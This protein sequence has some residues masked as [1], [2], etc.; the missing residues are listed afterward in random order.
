MTNCFSMVKPK[1]RIK[2][3]KSRRK[4][5]SRSYK[6][7]TSEMLQLAVESVANSTITT[8]EAEKQFGIPRR[9]IVNRLKNRHS[10]PVGKPTRL[11]EEEENKLINVVIASADYGSP[12][13]KLD[14]RI[15]VHNYLKKNGKDYIFNKKMPGE[16]WVNNLL[17][18]HNEKLTVRSTQNIS[19]SRAQ[20][21]EDEL[22][23]YFKNL[24]DTLKDIP[25]ANIL[26]YDETNCSDDPGSLKAIFRRGVKYPE[27]II[28]STKG[29]V[30]LMFSGT[31]DG[32]CLPPYVVYRADNL[33]NE[34]ILNGPTDARYNCTRSGWF[35]AAM[36]EDYFRSVV[37]EWAK[38]LP[39]LKVVIGDNLSSHLSPEIVQLSEDHEIKFVFL[40]PNS[41]HL[42]QPLDIAFFGP[43]KKEWRKILLKYK[44]E[45][46]AQKTVNKK[47]FPTLLK[48]LIE[49][50]ELHQS[51]NLRSGFKAAGIYPLNPRE[52]LKRIPEFEFSD[53]MTYQID[54]SLLDYLKQSRAPNPIKTV[55]NKKIYIEPGKSVSVTDFENRELLEKPGRKGKTKKDSDKPKPKL[56]KMRNDKIKHTTK[57]SKVKNDDTIIYN[58]TPDKFTE[59]VTDDIQNTIYIDNPKIEKREESTVEINILNEKTGIMQTYIKTNAIIEIPKSTILKDNFKLKPKT[60]DDIKKDNIEVY[61]SYI[62]SSSKENVENSSDNKT[63]KT[64]KPVN[65]Q[66]KFNVDK[67]LT[68]K[69]KNAPA[70]RLKILQS[71]SS[72]TT[73]AISMSE[74]SDSDLFDIDLD[75][76]DDPG[77]MLDDSD[78]T[79]SLKLNDIDSMQEMFDEDDEVVKRK[80]YERETE[81]FNEILRIDLEND[82]DTKIKDIKTDRVLNDRNLKKYGHTE[83]IQRIELA[84]KRMINEEQIDTEK[85]NTTIFNIGDNVIVRYYLTKKWQYYVGEITDIINKVENKYK[86]SYYKTI[87]K[88]DHVKFKKPRRPD[89]DVIPHDL[90]VKQVDLLQI[91][92]N[93]EFVLFDDEDSVVY[94]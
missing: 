5:G 71:T 87:S 56:K 15:L 79:H 65:F 20:K 6:N 14:L 84:D 73:E 29:C 59:A 92:E 47:H 27:R 1:P 39:G 86:I 23:N 4:L 13:T 68:K 3:R 60:R 72:T 80:N 21:G 67:V 64:Y 61:D 42:T 55:R 54:E 74:H 85:D 77:V 25:P 34:W 52:V 10:K 82:K 90:I 81:I 78:D 41:T 35:D 8:R 88:K 75:Q 24:R 31:A 32:K 58:E 48:T 91:N 63:T 70:K 93:N 30:S 16:K 76:T 57:D 7:Y 26:N 50:I 45:N 51:K 40:P 62:D 36:F 53:S 89:I 12:L 43:L 69:T 66:H 44:I 2:K 49:N 17:S 19:T 33:Y 18:R 83:D 22:L 38:R 11:S 9:T 28:N 46:P 94:F 37:L